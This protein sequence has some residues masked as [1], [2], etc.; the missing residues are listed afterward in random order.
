MTRKSQESQLKCIDYCLTKEDVD[1]KQVYFDFSEGCYAH[2]LYIQSE[3]N[4]QVDVDFVVEVNM[5]MFTSGK[6]KIAGCTREF[7]ID[8][9]L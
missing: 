8:K 6:I 3:K 4:I 1:K 7:Q 5:F 2:T 9:A